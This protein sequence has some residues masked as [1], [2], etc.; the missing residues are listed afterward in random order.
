M[1]D[2]SLYDDPFE[3][4]LGKSTRVTQNLPCL[5]CFWSR[6]RGRKRSKQWS[7][8]EHS[9]GRVMF[10]VHPLQPLGQSMKFPLVLKIKRVRLISDSDGEYV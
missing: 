2:A 1:R 9:L 5:P 3:L 8:K 6:R 10:R 7:Q 4:E